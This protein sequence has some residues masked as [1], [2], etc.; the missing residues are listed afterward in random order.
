MKVNPTGTTA[1]ALHTYEKYA[2]LLEIAPT[3]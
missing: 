3:H 2:S 1:L